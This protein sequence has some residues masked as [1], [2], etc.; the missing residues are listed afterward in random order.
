MFWLTWLVY[1]KCCVT[2]LLEKTW[3]DLC[4]EP[5]FRDVFK[6]VFNFPVILSLVRVV[7]T[8]FFYQCIV[9]SLN[10]VLNNHNM[11]TRWFCKHAE[12]FE[13]EILMKIWSK[14]KISSRFEIQSE[15]IFTQVVRIVYPPRPLILF[16]SRR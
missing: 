10:N 16:F 5:F 9:L 6:Q 3:E 13:S 4:N 12:R 15:F 8:Q 7:W 11:L 2:K 14:S 1:W